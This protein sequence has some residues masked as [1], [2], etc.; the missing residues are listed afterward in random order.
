MSNMWV[1]QQSMDVSMYGRMVA[2]LGVAGST[3]VVFRCV[4]FECQ[5]MQGFK[6]E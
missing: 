3:G 5:S 2:N 4:V 1:V 6:V